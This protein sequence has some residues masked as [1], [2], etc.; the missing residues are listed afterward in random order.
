MNPNVLSPLSLSGIITAAI[1]LMKTTYLRILGVAAVVFLPASLL[2]M[3]GFTVM[4]GMLGE[5]ANGEEL[6]SWANLARLL[7]SFVIIATAA[8]LSLLS[9]NASTV[10]GS[11]IIASEFE[12]TRLSVG[13]ALS[14]VFHKDTLNGFLLSFVLLLALF[15]VMALFFVLIL[16]MA[17]G[18]Q[19]NGFA[20]VFLVFIMFALLLPSILMM[21]FYSQVGMIVISWEHLGPF[22]ALGRASHLM[23]GLWWRTLGVWFF[24]TF[25]AY[26]VQMVISIPFFI[27]TLGP[28]YYKMFMMIMERGGEQLDPSDINRLF[29]QF[30]WA[31]GLISYVSSVAF[32]ALQPIYLS[33]IFAD[34]RARKGS[35]VT[36]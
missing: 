3:V 22:A 18:G 14:N 8:V 28:L 27:T 31:I 16:I 29:A 11:R 24:M 17:V 33:V 34:L 9:S 4:Y 15:M 12:G 36:A 2:S 25:I 1:D 30:G 32:S 35:P 21:A 23:G 6:P 19:E 5:F 26:V 20:L 13:H 10:G 7:F